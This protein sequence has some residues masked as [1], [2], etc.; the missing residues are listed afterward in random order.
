MT[1]RKNESMEQR[2][3]DYAAQTRGWNIERTRDMFIAAADALASYKDLEKAARWAKNENL[4][5]CRGTDHDTDC[6]QL[7]LDA[8]L[9]ALPSESSARDAD[10]NLKLQCAT[11][12]HASGSHDHR[13]CLRP[14]C[15]CTYLSDSRSDDIDIVPL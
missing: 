1:E 8:A 12:T 7:A 5:P 9:D 10:A 13:G 6:Y 15:K 11:C 3:R 4:C 14:G 2:L